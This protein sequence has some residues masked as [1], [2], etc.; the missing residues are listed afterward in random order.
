MI[1][2]SIKW[3]FSRGFHVYLKFYMQAATED[4]MVVFSLVVENDE[5]VVFVTSEGELKIKIFSQEEPLFIAVLPS[6]QWIT[7]ALSYTLKS[8]LLKNYYEV[9]CVIDGE[10]H[11]R[12]DLPVPQSVGMSDEII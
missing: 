5:F 4:D 11:E 7:L 1:N 9:H 10:M 6:Q 3:P 12:R 2:K 8:K